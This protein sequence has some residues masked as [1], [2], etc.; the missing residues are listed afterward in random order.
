MPPDFGVGLAAL[1]SSGRRCAVIG[2]GN[3]DRGDDGFGIS[4]AGALIQAGWPDVFIAGTAPERT[5]SG[6]G[7]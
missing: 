7:A 1:F 2:V 6:F 5:L 4:M 3:R